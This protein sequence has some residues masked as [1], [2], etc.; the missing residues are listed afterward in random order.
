MSR[1]KCIQFLMTSKTS[2]HYFPCTMILI[3]THAAMSLYAYPQV[4]TGSLK[5]LVS[6]TVPRSPYIF[7]VETFSYLRTVLRRIVFRMWKGL[8][9]PFKL[10]INDKM[11]EMSSRS[12]SSSAMPQLAFLFLSFTLLQTCNYY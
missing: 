2:I 6:L 11:C 1:R 5:K 3:T 10:P 8:E 12:K 7:T 4:W 9:I